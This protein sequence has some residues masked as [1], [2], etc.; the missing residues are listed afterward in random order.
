MGHLPAIQKTLRDLPDL[1]SDGLVSSNQE[2]DRWIA[3]ERTTLLRLVHQDKLR[4]IV[5]HSGTAFDKSEQE[6]L[7]LT[8]SRSR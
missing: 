4:A 8:E 2:L 3:G 1:C 5:V 6:V 7:G